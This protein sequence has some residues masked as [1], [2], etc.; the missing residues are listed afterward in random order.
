VAWELRKDS[1]FSVDPTLYC[2]WIAVPKLHDEVT[3]DFWESEGVLVG[4]RYQEEINGHT[5]NS[6]STMVLVHS[7]RTTRKRWKPSVAVKV[8]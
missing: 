2:T 3:C 7:A 8:E 1:A 4:I 6:N 5:D